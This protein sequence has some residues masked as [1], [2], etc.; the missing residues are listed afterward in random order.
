MFT[1]LFGHYLLNKKIINADQLRKALEEKNNTRVKLGALAIDEGYMLAEHV[2]AVHEAQRTTDKRFG[3]LA[4]SMGFLTDFQVGELLAKQKTA[5]IVLGQTLI[6]L[7]FMSNKQFEDALADYKANA[8]FIEENESDEQLAKDFVSILDLGMIPDRTFYL[9]YILLLVRNTIRFVGDDFAIVNCVKNEKKN[10]KHICSQEVTG[11]VAAY[12]AIAADDKPFMVLGERFAG[13]TIEAPDEF[14][15]A[16][17]GEFL[18]QHNGVYSVNISNEKN[19]ELELTPQEAAADTE[20]DFSSGICVTLA[21]SFG[22]V[23]FIV[24]KK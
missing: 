17:V 12:T 5:N 10:V 6:D 3:D 13:E 23:D 7:G 24:I 11:P 2:E 20:A 22:D 16:C 18:N 1:Q 4:V 19:I 9:E 14:A 8:A 21:F 15:E